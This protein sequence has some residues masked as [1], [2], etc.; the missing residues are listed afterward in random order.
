MCVVAI[1]RIVRGVLTRMKYIDEL[2]RA[3]DRRKDEK[4]RIERLRR[5]RSKERELAL[6]RKISVE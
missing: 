1:Q 6:L 4:E 3:K 5:I 2:S